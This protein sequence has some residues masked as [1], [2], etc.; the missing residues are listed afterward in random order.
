MR[1]LYRSGMVVEAST[2]V[3][4]VRV[5][6]A[7]DT[8]SSGCARSLP[9]ISVA[10]VSDAHPGARVQLSLSARSLNRHCVALF[11][12][13]LL[14]VVGLAVLDLS[15][16]SLEAI[17]AAVLVGG[18]L[19]LWSG[20]RLALAGSQ[21]LSVRVAAVQAGVLPMNEYTKE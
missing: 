19:A 18:S 14:V 5:D 17:V 9:D 10:P 7:C 15:G 1:Q 6:R 21:P 2:E 4:R 8:C 12:P 16:A 3:L 11:G 13:W 20:R